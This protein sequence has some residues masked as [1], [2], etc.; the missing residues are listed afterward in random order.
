MGEKLPT[1]R[2]RSD[3]VNG[4]DGL[5]IPFFEFK[6]PRAP[7]WDVLDYFRNLWS[8]NNYPIVTETEKPQAYIWERVLEATSD[9]PAARLLTAYAP[10]DT[11]E[12]QAHFTQ[13][14]ARNYRRADDFTAG[15]LAVS[16]RVGKETY[17]LSEAGARGFVLEVQVVK[18]LY[19]GLSINPGFSEIPPVV[20]YKNMR[21]RAAPPTPIPQQRTTEQPSAQLQESFIQLMTFVQN[22]LMI[23]PE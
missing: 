2:E 7:E 5:R 13:I 14:S 11:P 17:S 18:G 6:N 12:L 20:S 22:T 21:L 4:R 16:Y 3:T 1:G 10:V 15:G 9:R 23:R 19:T 8:L